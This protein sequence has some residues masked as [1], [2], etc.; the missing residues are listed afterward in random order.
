M[1][2]LTDFPRRLRAGKTVFLGETHEE[3]RLHETRQHNHGLLIRFEHILTRDEAEPLCGRMVYV[4]SENIPDL[5]EGEYYH[6]QLLGLT[7]R[8]EEGRTLG[9]LAEILATGA[10]D[11]YVVRPPEPE[12][13]FPAPADI[14][15][16]AI[17]EVIREIDLDAQTI[18]VRLLPGLLPE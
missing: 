10:N 1:S 3:T 11:V 13:G 7:V 2:V 5:P 8:T 6:H 12:P 15:L 17:E 16:P 9:V 14:L 4:S 18:S